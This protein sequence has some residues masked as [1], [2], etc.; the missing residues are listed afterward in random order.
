MT[1]FYE[2][3]KESILKSREKNKEKYNEYMRKYQKNKKNK[4]NED[5]IQKRINKF[6]IEAEKLG[7]SVNKKD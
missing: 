2:K 4:I 5:K 3:N 7:Y 6:L 1:S